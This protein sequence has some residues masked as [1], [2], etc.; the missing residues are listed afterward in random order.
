[1]PLKQMKLLVTAIV[2][3]L[4]ASAC[5]GG[6]NAWTPGSPANGR[7][8]DLWEN[9]SLQQGEP[10]EHSLA[11]SSG[12]LVVEGGG[13]VLAVLAWPHDQQ[14]LLL[15]DY[16]DS[17]VM[18]TVLDLNSL[19][20][21]PLGSITLEGEKPV[22]AGYRYPQMLLQADD[23]Q[24]FF[25]W[26][27]VDIEEWQILWQHSSS[28]PE[29]LR[30]RPVWHNGATWLLGP[31]SG[32]GILDILTGEVAVRELL[33][34][35][36][37]PLTQAWP[38]WSGP[39]RVGSLFAYPATDDSQDVIALADT[40]T[41]EQWAFPGGRQIAWAQCGGWVAWIHMD[42]LYVFGPDGQIR[43]PQ[44]DVP[45]SSPMWS[46]DSGRLFFIAGSEDY[47]GV[48]W[49]ELWSWQEG[50]EPELVRELP[51]A[52]GRWRLLAAADEAVLAAAGDNNELFMYMDFVGDRQ[53]ELAGETTTSWLWHRGNLFAENEGNL[54]R[55]SPGGTKRTLDAVEG[56]L[57]ILAVIE[58]F[59]IFTVD[60]QLQ[61]KQVVL[62][63]N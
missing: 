11:Q 52:L 27:L 40:Q 32:P 15:V 3:A 53:W 31:V 41:G 2:I 45:A 16:A 62:Q 13:Q 49:N 58:N 46:Q 56:D 7:Q 1:M 29:G 23:G 57:K 28:V 59:L 39:A 24:G 5:N 34:T 22:V 36:V 9:I 10:T 4:I 30:R 55:I 20:T 38:R 25:Q 44:P 50:E 43:Q 63:G 37:N 19:S 6:G 17:T 35:P 54:I 60:G 12:D 33:Y 14:Q 51:P 26:L 18:L 48:T 21:E 47:L 42:R 8:Q 61:I